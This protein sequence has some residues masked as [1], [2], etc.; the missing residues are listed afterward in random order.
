MYKCVNHHFYLI[1]QTHGLE[2][3]Y[4]LY[5][6]IHK[7][8]CMFHKCDALKLFYFDIY[9]VLIPLRLFMA[10]ETSCFKITIKYRILRREF[11][12]KDV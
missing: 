6:I 9:F 8:S 11:L 10:H 1:F 2:L 12:L 4:S 5:A 7:S 3:E